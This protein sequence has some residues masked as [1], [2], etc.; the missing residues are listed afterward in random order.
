MGW[1]DH[2]DRLMALADIAESAGL[3]Y[4]EAYALAIDTRTEELRGSDPVSEESFYAY[5]LDIAEE[6]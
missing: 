5:A 2:D 4:A 1:N 6:S 3:E